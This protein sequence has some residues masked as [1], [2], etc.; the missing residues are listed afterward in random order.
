M[1][2]TFRGIVNDLQGKGGAKIR[3]RVI[4]ESGSMNSPTNEL[5]KSSNVVTEKTS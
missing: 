2:N 1:A 3:G 4:S 5:E